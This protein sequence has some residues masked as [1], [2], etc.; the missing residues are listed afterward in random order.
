[1]SPSSADKKP[2]DMRLETL[3]QVNER[4]LYLNK[5]AIQFQHNFNV[6]FSMQYSDFLSP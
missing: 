6:I 2:H 1:M 5:H 3:S 4:W